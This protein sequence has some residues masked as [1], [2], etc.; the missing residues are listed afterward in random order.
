MNREIC[1]QCGQ[2]LDPNWIDE[3]IQKLESMLCE[4]IRERDSLRAHLHDEH[5]RHVGTMDER[6]ALQAD[7]AAARADAERL[8]HDLNDMRAGHEVLARQVSISRAL[9][10]ECAQAVQPPWQNPDDPLWSLKNRINSTFS[11][12][13]EGAALAGEKK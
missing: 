6:D 5:Q 13:S 12:Q 10:V 8:R 4:A 3:R 2:S 7:L 11:G 9:L 1:G